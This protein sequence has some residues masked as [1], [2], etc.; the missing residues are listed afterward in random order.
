M[1]TAP[2]VE[3]GL[4]VYALVEPADDVGWGAGGIEQAS[5][6]AVPCGPLAAVVSRVH[7]PVDAWSGNV[8]RYDEVLRRL[9]KCCREVHPVPFGIVVRDERELCRAILRII[10]GPSLPG[11]A[12]EMALSEMRDEDDSLPG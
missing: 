3:E 1:S 2:V 11:T 10:E 5:V 6:H 7:S 12:L 8:D 4:F 9:S